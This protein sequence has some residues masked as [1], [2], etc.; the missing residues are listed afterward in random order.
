MCRRE[1]Q[2]RTVIVVTLPAM[3]GPRLG[4]PVRI[5]QQCVTGTQ[6]RRTDT[7]SGFG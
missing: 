3:T 1:T 7:K 2:Q 6:S 5:E 4:Q